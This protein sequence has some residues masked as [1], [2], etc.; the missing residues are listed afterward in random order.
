[1][2]VG[3][4]ER[5]IVL[6]ACEIRVCIA[7]LYLGWDAGLDGAGLGMLDSKESTRRVTRRVRE[8]MYC[9]WVSRQESKLLS[10][11]I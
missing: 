10:Y 7:R 8:C 2:W 9:K 4:C 3:R 5:E 6:C 1:M 11:S